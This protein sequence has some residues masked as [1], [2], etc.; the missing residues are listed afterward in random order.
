M[1]MIAALLQAALLSRSSLMLFS[2]DQKKKVVKNKLRVCF[3][4]L[5]FHFLGGGELTRRTL[6]L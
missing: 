2:P 4:F 5:Y 3:V 6:K 1:C